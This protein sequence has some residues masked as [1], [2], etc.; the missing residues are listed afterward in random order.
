MKKTSVP[1]Q[2][3]LKLET[4]KK[5]HLFYLKKVKGQM[6]ASLGHM[7]GHSYPLLEKVAGCSK[8]SI[9]AVFTFASVVICFWKKPQEVALYQKA[10]F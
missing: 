3:L 10:M 2:A 5:T 8:H 6:A 4:G 7:A 9:T 1:Q